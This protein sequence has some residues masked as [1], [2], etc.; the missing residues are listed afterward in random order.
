METSTRYFV[1]SKMM[2]IIDDL[3]TSRLNQLT[4]RQYAT[5]NVSNPER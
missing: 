2:M 3:P 1:I 5:D 4:Y